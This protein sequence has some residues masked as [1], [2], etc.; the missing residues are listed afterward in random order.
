MYADYNV[1]FLDDFKHLFEDLNTNYYGMLD[2]LIASKGRTF[3]GTFHSTFTGYINR[4]RGYHSQK[5]KLEGYETGMIRSYYFN[6]EDRKNAML[7]YAPVK[8][9]HP[10]Y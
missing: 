5:N 1:Y 10:K 2:Q 4:M 3:I 9:L 6:P 7:K 8:I